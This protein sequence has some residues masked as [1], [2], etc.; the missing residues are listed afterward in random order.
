M[1]V[2]FK[3]WLGVVMILSAGIAPLRAVVESSSTITGDWQVEVRAKSPSGSTIKVSLNIDPSPKASVRDEPCD[4][5]PDFNPRAW[6]GW[7]KGYALKGVRAQECTVKGALDPLSLR[8]T[9]AAGLASVVYTRGK[10]YEADLAWGAVGRL[11]SG[12]ISEKEKVLVSYDYFLQRID[13]VVLSA[14]GNEL[15][16]KKGVPD[17]CQPKPQQL[18]EGEIALIYIYVPAG[19][20]KLSRE[21]LFPV[22]ETDFPSEL[23]AKDA[24]AAE[25]LLP[26]TMKKLREGATLKIL[27]WG[28]SVTEGR[29]LPEK[30]KNRWQNQFVNRLKERYPQANIELITVAWGGHSTK[31]FIDQPPGGPF[32]YKEKVLAAKPDLIVMEFINDS[33][34]KTA[35]VN[36]RYGKFRDDFKS[37]GA[38]WIINTPHYMRHD[39]MGLKS[40]REIDDD[41]REYVKVLREFA[42]QNNIAIADISL[43]YGRLW[44]Q[45]IPYETLMMNGINHPDPQ[46]LMIFADAVMNLFP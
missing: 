7:Q 9:E 5:L 45:G 18:A 34:L 16:H 3:M 25:K 4:K 20:V 2:F 14:T 26:K 13:T 17:I 29:Y 28:D 8:V 19:A 24:G 10:D 43:R 11:P 41:P 21:N 35:E 33:G 42:T 46:G 32:N 38:E 22:L 15:L 36:E 37:I 12:G 23:A 1:N 30:E 27:A 6:G 44:R 40:Q 39:W 31:D